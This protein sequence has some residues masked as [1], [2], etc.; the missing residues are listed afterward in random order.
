MTPATEPHISRLDPSVSLNVA[1]QDWKER[2]KKK[3]VWR[4]DI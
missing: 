1:A 2:G 3:D 4:K